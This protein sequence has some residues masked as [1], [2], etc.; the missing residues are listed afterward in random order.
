MVKRIAPDKWRHFFVGI[1]MGAVLQAFLLFLLPAH[2]VLGTL[3]TFLLVIA[4]SYGFELTSKLTRRGH[5]DL[6]DA[7]A[8]II[9][10]MLG[11]GFLI[12]FKIDSF[13][14]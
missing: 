11:M 6:M 12:L 7:V 10:G 3:I 13:S 4:I 9:G 8:S 14:V 5:Y 2:P 1:A